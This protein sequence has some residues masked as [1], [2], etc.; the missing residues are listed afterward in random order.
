MFNRIQIILL[1]CLIF[2]FCCSIFDD[3]LFAFIFLL[4]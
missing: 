3:M 4:D 1:K 2:S